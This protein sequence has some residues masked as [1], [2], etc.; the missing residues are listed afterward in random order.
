VIT[1]YNLGSH[2]NKGIKM[3]A[4]IEK[5]LDREALKI[6]REYFGKIALPTIGLAISIILLFLTVLILFANNYLSPV[7]ATMSIGILT[8]ASYTPMHEAVHGNIGG[9]NKNFK[10]LD[11]VVGY[12]M[13][14]IISIPFTSHQKE[15]LVHHSHTNTDKDPDVHIENLFKSPKHFYTAII[16]VIKTQNTFVMNNYTRAEIFLSIGWRLL[17]VL[18]TGMVGIP[19]LLIGWFLGSFIT[20]YFLSYK[21]HKPYKDTKRW[22]NA[23]ISLLPIQ[24]L[25]IFLFYHNLHAIH[26]LFPRIPFYSYRKVFQ[27]IEKTMRE[28]ETPIISILNQRPI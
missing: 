7:F 24:S 25:E 8:F 3:S 11:K 18:F 23:S 22:K 28:K 4:D 21:P 10:W 26:H 15:H 27:R 2:P 20:V 9:T 6:S 19:V 1:Q 12:L 5:N 17:F 13:A 16:Q 14:P